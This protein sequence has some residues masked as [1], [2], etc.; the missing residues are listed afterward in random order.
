MSGL[1][2]GEANFRRDVERHAMDVQRSIN[3]C[4]LRLDSQGVINV[5]DYGAKGDGVTDDTAALQAA[6]DAALAGGL[7]LIGAP[8]TYLV[9]DTWLLQ[10]SG[11][12]STMTVEPT[13]ASVT[14]VVRVGSLT[15]TTFPDIPRGLLLALP[16][17][18]NPLKPGTGWTGIESTV[19][20]ECANLYESSVVVSSIYGFGV[21]L[22]CAGYT[23]G[24]VYNIF[25]LSRLY[26]NKINLQLK[27]GGTTGWTNQ[28]TFIGGRYVHDSAEGDT[29]S[30]VAHIQL[31]NPV[32][33]VNAPP[34]NNLFLNP[35]IEGKVPQYHLDIQGSVNTFLNPRFEVPSGSGRVRYYSLT[36]GETAANVLSGGYDFGLS[37]TIDGASAPY[38][39]R[40]NARNANSMEATGCLLSLGNSYS[41]T[42]T[43]PHLQGFVAGTSP[44]D[45]SSSSTDW[46]Y[47]LYA[48]GM[49]FKGSTDGYAKLKLTSS[50]LIYLGDGTAAA[51]SFLVSSSGNIASNASI[52][53]YT[54]IGAN[55]GSSGK[56]WNVAYIKDGRIGRMTGA[57]TVHDA[58]DYTLSSGWGDTA[59]LTTVAARD[60]GGRLIVL[61]GGT[62]IAAN[63]SI[64]LTFADGAWSSFP[65]TVCSDGNTPGMADG[66]WAVTSISATAMVLTFYGT[67]VSGTAY[68][69]NFITMGR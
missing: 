62:G 53:P 34:N 24:C 12:L 46:Q 9:S 31:A 19:G 48:N 6:A 45:K 65:A 49:S 41:S 69:V 29:V 15:G 44:I 54:D 32:G 66:R 39:S 8:G 20:V 47:R 56:R 43:A 58:S 1:R 35:S 5:K 16:S 14:P 33:A 64:T 11:D 60:T 52:A 67:P 2:Q 38:N 36:A 23:S 68:A 10:C 7:K 26:N 3:D 30:G 18:T 22:R 40:I 61:C 4:I 51:T 42:E 25:T 17:V 55:L 13:A 63:P 59:S 21:G 37:Y 57:G 28:N 27:P 50:G